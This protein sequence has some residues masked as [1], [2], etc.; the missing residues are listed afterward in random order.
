M[1]NMGTKEAKMMM[2][3][4]NEEEC[5]NHAGESS[6]VNK[7]LIEGYFWNEGECRNNA[8]ERSM[9]NKVVVEGY[10]WPTCITT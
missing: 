7:V 8:G 9:V 3:M 1:L 2:D 10:F 4:I 6:V 5:V